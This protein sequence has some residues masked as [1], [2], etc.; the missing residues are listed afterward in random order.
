MPRRDWRRVRAT[1]LQHAF[2]LCID[3]SRER[4]NRSIDQIADHMGLPSKWAIYKWV[5][6]ANMPAVKLRAFE[7]ACGATFVTEYLAA[8]AHRLLIQIPT[9]KARTPSDVQALQEAC[10]AA[11][12]ALIEFTQGKRTATDTSVALTAAMERLAAERAQVDRH[13]QPE[14][15]LT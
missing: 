1:S 12:G 3:F 8:S 13:A 2:E 4:H 14:L 5:E 9:G 6:G 10:T 15:D 7:T 11:V